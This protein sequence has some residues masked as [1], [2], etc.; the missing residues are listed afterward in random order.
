MSLNRRSGRVLAG[1]PGAGFFAAACFGGLAIVFGSYAILSGYR[2]HEGL[3]GR[4]VGIL[5]PGI[6]L[7]ILVFWVKKAGPTRFR[8]T[9]IAGAIPFHSE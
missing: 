9:R 1:L 2:E 6:I 4:F 3:K 8:L 7:I 5:M